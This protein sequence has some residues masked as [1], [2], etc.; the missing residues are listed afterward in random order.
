VRAAAL[1]AAAAALALWL[2]MA[3]WSLPQVA[4]GAGGLAPFD[5]R[6][7]GYGEAEARAVLAAL[8]PEARAF[9]ASTQHRLDLIFPGVLALALSL[10]FLRLAPPGALRWTLVA[11]AVAA[12]GLDW[13]ENAAVAQMLA[14]PPAEVPADLIARA[15]ALTV[16]KSAAVTVALV[17]LLVLAARAL[18]RRV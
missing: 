15:S 16:A 9:Y 1:A 17:A 14:L 11:V 4:A 7:L 5:L 10:A 2:V 18:H 3:L 13:A 12:A 8:T 6:P